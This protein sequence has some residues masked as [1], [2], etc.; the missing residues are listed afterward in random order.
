MS[1]LVGNPKH[2]FYRDACHIHFSDSAIG[3]DY[4]DDRCNKKGNSKDKLVWFYCMFWY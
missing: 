1:D 3:D 2:R 4:D